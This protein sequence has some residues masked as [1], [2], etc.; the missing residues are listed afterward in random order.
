MK[1]R[2]WRVV[3]RR[4]F[5]VGTA[6]LVAMTLA[7]SACGSGSG[8]GGAQ[9]GTAAQPSSPA[10]A[11]SGCSPDS[12][13]T[14]VAEKGA[15][16]SG[17]AQTLVEVPANQPFSLCIRNQDNDYHNLIVFEGET[18]SESPTRLFNSGRILDPGQEATYQVK[19]IPPGKHFFWCA[20]HPG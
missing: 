17:W 12:T 8:S 20:V 10:K 3:M 13:V 2:G 7:G 9:P 1:T 15:G 11:A 19:P 5:A 16:K 18:A 4:Q 14:L 6:F